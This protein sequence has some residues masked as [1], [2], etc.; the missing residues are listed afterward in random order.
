[1]DNIVYPNDD[2][3][4]SQLSLGNP[5]GLQGG[6][7]MTKILYK[8]QPLYI[9]TPKSLSKQGFIKHPKKYYLELMFDNNDEKLF[10]WLENLEER[11][12]KLIYE[13]GETWFQNQLELNDIENAFATT[14]RPYKSCK[15]YLLRVNVKMNYQTNAPIVKIYNENQSALTIDDVHADTNIIS[16]LEIQGIRF[17]SRNFQIEMELK[18]VMTLNSEVFFDSCLIKPSASIKEKQKEEYKEEIK[19]I[20]ELKVIVEKNQENQEELIKENDLENAMEENITNELKEFD[21]TDISTL[22]TMTLKKPN[23]VYYEIY[24]ETRKK[25]KLAKKE[26]ILAFLEAK[27]IK[28]TYMLENV[29]DSDSDNDSTFDNMSDYSEEEENKV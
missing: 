28:K 4:F 9:Q 5:T 7:Y 29:D 18:Q 17:S 24:K 3:D 1:M 19:E 2:F 26:A 27:N 6:A 13:K 23:Q 25:A 8:D 16:I 10:R 22:E 15:Y 21:I 20:K 12:Q 11:C 14:I